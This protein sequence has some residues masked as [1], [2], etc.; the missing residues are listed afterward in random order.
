MQ[1]LLCTASR[2]WYDFINAAVPPPCSVTHPLHFTF[3]PSL[4]MTLPS[5]VSAAGAYTVILHLPV[6]LQYPIVVL[7]AQTSHSM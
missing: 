7:G 6:I 4:P 3:Q 1:V 2:S 5:D